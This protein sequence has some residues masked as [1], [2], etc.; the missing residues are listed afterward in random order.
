MLQLQFG[1]VIIVTCGSI[2]RVESLFIE[3]CSETIIMT[4]HEHFPVLVHESEGQVLLIQFAIL[5]EVLVL[6]HLLVFVEILEAQFVKLLMLF[7]E[8]VNTLV[9]LF[10]LSIYI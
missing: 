8:D 7:G 4:L 10:Y 2:P 9:A 5:L 3:A 6:D 1:I